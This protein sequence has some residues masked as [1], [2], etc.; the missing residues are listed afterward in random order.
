MPAEARCLLARSDHDSEEAK[1]G[2]PKDYPSSI[3]Q[4][5]RSDRLHSRRRSQSAGA[6]DRARSRWSCSRFA[7]RTLPSGSRKPRYARSCR[8]KAIPQP[9]RR[10]E[11]LVFNPHHQLIEDNFEYLWE[12]LPHLALAC[13]LILDSILCWHPSSSIV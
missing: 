11:G 4:R 1:L 5:Q 12:K 10:E 2:T 9:L 6:L 8:P 13:D 3:E 7:W